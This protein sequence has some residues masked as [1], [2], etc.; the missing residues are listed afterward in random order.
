MVAL[1]VLSGGCTVERI[2]QDAAAGF[3]YLRLRNATHVEANSRWLMSPDTRIEV[4]AIA[5]AARTDW[6]SAAREGMGSI[7][8]LEAPDAAGTANADLIVLIAWPGDQLEGAQYGGFIKYLRI[9]KI[10]LG[11]DPMTLRVFLCDARTE[12]LIQSANLD[13]SPRWFSPN[14]SR[15]DHIRQAFRV[16]AQGLVSRY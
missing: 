3:D 4:S 11:S 1:L 6:L 13:L 16:Y 5:P 9:D 10:I 15:D 12:T 7:F 8:P 14:G 2:H